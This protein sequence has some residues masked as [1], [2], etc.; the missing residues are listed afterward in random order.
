MLERESLDLCALDCW[1]S[2]KMQLPADHEIFEGAIRN[3]GSSW[4]DGGIIGVNG[5]SVIRF[6]ANGSYV[7]LSWCSKLG[8]VPVSFV[9]AAPI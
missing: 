3:S 4:M 5:W 9:L 7:L 6:H 2:D 8:A 1:Q